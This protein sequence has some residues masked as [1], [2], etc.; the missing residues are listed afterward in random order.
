M[1]YVTMQLLSTTE[2]FNERDICLFACGYLFQ[3]LTEA[4]ET[5]DA[6]IKCEKIF[7]SKRVL[8]IAFPGVCH[9]YYYF[10]LRFIPG[11]ELIEKCYGHLECLDLTAHL[12][13]ADIHKPD[14]YISW[15]SYEQI[16]TYIDP[17]RHFLKWAQT[18]YLHPESHA[19][20]P[21]V[22]VL[23]E[24][25]LAHLPP[26]VK[27]LDGKGELKSEINAVVSASGISSWGIDMLSVKP[28]IVCS[29]KEEKHVILHRLKNS[30]HKHIDWDAC[31][32]YQQSTAVERHDD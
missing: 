10:V 17:V 11:Y 31:L 15:C 22:H 16:R 1:Y 4:Q 24:N 12:R 28:S 8:N 20:N 32:S 14:V 23:R 3:C 5:L 29:G 26:L 25:N 21:V 9:L 18:Y 7:V 2:N 27:C 19:T 30:A 13:K 6:L